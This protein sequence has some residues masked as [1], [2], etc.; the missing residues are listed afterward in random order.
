[1]HRLLKWLIILSFMGVAPAL[2]EQQPPARVGRVALVSGNLAFHMAGEA[3]WSATGVNYPVATG[4]SFWTDADSRAEIRIGPNTIGI[5]SSTELDV[6]RLDDQATQ[7][8]IPQGRIYLHLRRLDNGYTVEIDIPRGS[9]A[10]TQ[11]GYYDIDA[12]S[13][14]QPAR[15]F[16]FEGNAR[17]AGNNADIE[18]KAGDAAVLGG[19]GRVT[20]TLERA[21]ADAFIEWCRSQDYDEKRLAAPYHVSPNMTGYAELDS[22]GRWD[23]AAGYGEVWYPNVP[24]GWAPYTDGRWI[25][26]RPWG[27]T[28]VDAAPWGFAPCHYGRWALIGENWGWVSGSFVPAPVYAPALVGFLGGP[29]VG[30]YVSGAVGP[31]I[32]WFPLGPG[33]I[34]WPSYSR[35]VNYIRDINI[36]NMTNINNVNIRPNGDPPPEIARA[37]F[38]NRRFATVVPQ[39]VFAS[40]SKVDP[41]VARP[42]AAVLERAPVAMRAPQIRPA[43]AGTVPGPAAFR[44]RGQ[45]GSVLATPGRHAGGTDS[46]RGAADAAALRP[47]SGA[48]PG[49]IN[50]GRQPGPRTNTAAL[51]PAWHPDRVSARGATAA[52]PSTPLLGQQQ[53]PGSP[54][55]AHARAPV[56]VSQAPVQTFHPPPQVSHLPPQASHPAA[57]AFHPPAQAFHPL[58]QAPQQVAHAPPAP[59]GGGAPQSSPKGGGVATAHGGKGDKHD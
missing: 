28:W 5:A 34:Y 14:D 42:D 17:F 11:P 49:T 29:G 54:G 51:P 59:S 8:S 40:G 7:I 18:V 12:G 56:R 43:F 15:V 25:W 22:Y 4:G 58:A 47:P 16:V 41:V 1:M 39:H 35:N 46:L 23:N 24:T 30:L 33:E 20:A 32:G 36:A 44:V 55:V 3:Q 53:H 21:V 48:R 50:G 45:P 37:R 13:G 31:Q 57:Q 9:I 26:V 10:L 52:T 2:A 38:V 6:L 27:W 19:L